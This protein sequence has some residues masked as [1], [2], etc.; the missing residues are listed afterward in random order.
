MNQDLLE[1]DVNTTTALHK[2]RFIPHMVVDA[3]NRSDHQPCLFLDGKTATY[4]QVRKKVSQYAQALE[5]KNVGM[6]SRI[7]LLS[8][9]C[10]EVVFI[11]LAA[12]V[13]GCCVTPMH[14][15]G[16]LDDHAYVLQDAKIQTLVFQATNYEERAENLAKIVSHPIQFLSI[17]NSNTG[18]DCSQLANTFSARDLSVPN[19]KGDGMSNIVYT[20]GTTG[21]PKG[22]VHTYASMTYMTMMQ[23]A[24]WEIPSAV[25]FMVVT[26]LSH[27]GFTC[28]VPTLLR[29]G[30]LYVPSSFSPDTFFDMVSQHKI[31]ATMLVPAMLYV[32]LDHER[33]TTANMSSVNTIFYGASPISAIRLR[34]AIEMWGKIFSQFYG[35]V[36][37][38]TC[39]VNLRRE[40]H[41]LE[42]PGRLESCGRP[43]SWVQTK[44]LD[45]D[46]NETQIGDVGEIC[47]RGP[48]LMQHYLNKPSETAE[49]FTGDWLHTG[50]LGRFDE[51][52]FLYIVGRKKDMIV[53]GG[54]NVYPREIEDVISAN[55]HVQQAV[56]FGV[57]NDRWGEAVTAV[58]TLRPGV[59]ELRSLADALLEE[60]KV[61]KGPVQTPKT[62]HFVDSI[63]LTPVGKP[64]KRRLSE[65][66]ATQSDSE[67][68]LED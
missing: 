34:E 28:L 4:Q 29:G 64:D 41:D 20:G 54:F 55:K 16:S 68:A 63:P 53:T 42:K 14:P 25:R 45:E 30:C 10:P 15:K 39:F 9:N 52:G 23:M 37:A 3:L 31:T 43:S 62:I 51:E 56:V 1:T 38:P 21:T 22:V 49:A 17:G 47:V 59:K 67:A 19:I 13:V 50:D 65:V 27:A 46:G 24:E 57:P 61:A 40:D 32:L 66:Y 11:N 33:A 36:E 26:P 6:G 8:A 12:H 18:E 5:A 35:Q 7:A 2:K 48:L 44:L 60:V 58:I